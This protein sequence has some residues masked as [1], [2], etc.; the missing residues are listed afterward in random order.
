MT[1]SPRRLPLF[2]RPLPS[3]SLLSHVSRTA[4]E[5][6]CE[7]D[8]LMSAVGI[9]RPSG[10]SVGAELQVSMA[11]SQVR[12]YAQATGLSE[13]DVAR[14]QL[15]RYDGIAFDLGDAKRR[16]RRDH[17]GRFLARH[18]WV[19]VTHSHFCPACLDEQRGAWSL[20]WRL[21]WVFAC[22]EHGV[23]LA[24]RCPRCRVRPG[25]AAFRESPCVSAGLF[26]RPR[27]A[28][29][30]PAPDRCHAPASRSTVCGACLASLDAASP[31]A[32]PILRAQEAIGLALSGRPV[33]RGGLTLA[34][35]EFFG[36]LRSLCVTFLSAG[37]SS[38]AGGL[39]GPP[40]KV[41]SHYFT[42]RDRF[43][44]ERASSR[45]GLWNVWSPAPR[46]AALMAA[47]AQLALDALL[48]GSKT[49]KAFLEPIITRI[50]REG[51]SS[52][53]IDHV[54]RRFRYPT[55]LRSEYRD[56]LD[57]REAGRG[58][59]HAFTASRRS[60]P[61]FDPACIPQLIWHRVYEQ[62]FAELVQ[63]WESHQARRFC[64]LAL[65]RCGPC[66]TWRTAAK[67]LGFSDSGRTTQHFARLLSIV[68][69]ETQFVERIHRLAALI[70]R[71][72]P[73]VSY[74]AR[75]ARL[76]DLTGKTPAIGAIGRSALAKDLSTNERVLL[77]AWVWSETTSGDWRR[78]PAA[79]GGLACDLGT[80][81]VRKSEYG[82]FED[83]L[84]TE[85][86]FGL[87]REIEGRLL[88]GEPIEDPAVVDLAVD[89]T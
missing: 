55:W 76:S 48:G 6:G 44:A 18:E 77:A 14:L 54:P 42:K 11:P 45:R 5:L 78:S 28:R 46:E 3:E 74:I 86:R 26:A 10:D 83:S 27:P 68:G 71:A 66:L 35:L 38:M 72:E 67:S 43:R 85:A 21:P 4:W 37:D 30:L 81:T 52:L 56:A 36:A 88:D 89:L 61:R 65:L 47:V 2:V 16:A 57:A 9:V 31:A 7:R 53:R 15:S 64:S 84:S 17:L 70:G 1:S 20:E 59:R 58:F 49:T 13:D 63:G 39:A 19:Y 12:R 73:R 32:Q 8:E 33:R 50:A 34:P 25:M 22:L 79:Q 60:R 87:E 29:R 40:A 82:R 62:H 41:L 80:R 69:A 24:D 51:D 75:R 23:L